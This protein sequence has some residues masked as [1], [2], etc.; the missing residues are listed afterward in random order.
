MGKTKTK[1][2]SGPQQK[3]SN[4]AN[5][6][7][8]KGDFLEKCNQYVGLI[9]F[10]VAGVSFFLNVCIYVFERGRFNYWKIDSSYIDVLGN[11]GI[12]ALMFYAAIAAIIL[13]I[14]LWAYLI[15]LEHG[16]AIAQLIAV[17]EKATKKILAK[18]IKGLICLLFLFALVLVVVACIFFIPTIRDGI[19]GT[20]L[21]IFEALKISEIFG[22]VALYS[23][24]ISLLLLISGI[25]MGVVAVVEKCIKKKAKP[26][27]DKHKNGVVSDLR[28]TMI[29]VGACMLISILSIYWIGNSW[30]EGIR[31]I[32]TYSVI[33]NE[34][35]EPYQVVLHQGEDFY[36]V[37][38]CQIVDCADETTLLINNTVQTEIEKTDVKIIKM[39]FNHVEIE[40]HSI[41]AT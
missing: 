34:Q 37:A 29:A 27:S 19:E 12:F 21:G 15:V 11:N 40:D 6:P 25:V 3:A 22:V 41:F 14:N 13:F 5:I 16:V 20:G 1:S 38:D 18:L 26:N 33:W 30:P 10:C 31:N 24:L 35:N 7:E 36:L 39:K 23:G 4:D 17:R 8:N 9:T 32:T 28:D 2:S